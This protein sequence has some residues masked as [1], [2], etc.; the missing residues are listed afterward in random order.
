MRS[1]AGGIG[2][3]YAEPVS[4]R[5][6]AYEHCVEIGW[7]GPTSGCQAHPEPPTRGVSRE[8]RHLDPQQP[9]ALGTPDRAVTPRRA[10]RCRRSS[11]P[12]WTGGF[13]ALMKEISA[14]GEFVTAEALADPASSTIFGWSPEGHAGH[15]GPV[16]GGQGAAGR[17][18]PDRLRH[19]RS[20]PRRSRR[21]SPSP[22]APSSSGRRCGPAATTSDRRDELGAAPED[23]WRAARR[24][25]L[26]A[27][28]RRYGDFDAAEDAR[29][30][31]PAGRVP[32]V[33]DAGRAR[34]TRTAG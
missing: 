17:L 5:R 6:P 1:E 15:R 26:A 18:L 23:L 33:A 12:R 20:G 31:G 30:G 19:P 9:R 2:P 22:A 13:E 29:A 16:R 14:S 34:P 32:A 7:P 3:P 25:V 24:E 11:T 21:S 28:V 10:G 8:V 27:L 4:R